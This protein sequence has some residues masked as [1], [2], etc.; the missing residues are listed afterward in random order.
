MTRS[1]IE[2]LT[3][4]FTRAFNEDDLNAV[5][6]YFAEDGI[7]DEFDGRRHVGAA[8]IRKAFEPQF[9]GTFGKVRFRQED[10][11]VDA[12]TG[13]AMI[14]WTCTLETKQ[15]PAGW[16]GLDLLHWKAGR[17][18]QKHTYAKAKQLQLERR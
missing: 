9:S 5:M 12:E 6:A 16:R 17:L 14:S 10:L 3:L 7:Y 15:G 1:E 4:D 11:F 18:A 2:Q 8:A 13:K